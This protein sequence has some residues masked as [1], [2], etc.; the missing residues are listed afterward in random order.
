RTFLI[1]V[2]DDAGNVIDTQEHAVEFKGG[3]VHICARK[4]APKVATALPPMW[5]RRYFSN[6]DG[7]NFLKPITL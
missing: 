1:R 7:F 4:R 5:D 3:C 2:Y 6:P